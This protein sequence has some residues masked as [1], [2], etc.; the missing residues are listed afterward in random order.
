MFDDFKVNPG[1][2]ILICGKSGSGKSTFLNNLKE[3]LKKQNVC[4]SL[5]MQNFDAQIITDKVFHELAFPLENYGIKPDVIR[6][7]VAEISTYFGIT[8]LLEKDT[9]RLSGGEKQ[10]L[11]LASALITA[12]EILLLDEPASQLDPVASW[13]FFST[14][15]KLNRETGISVVIAEH[16]IE[17]VFPLADRIILLDKM[18]V[19]CEG[20][21]KEFAEN[22]I[23]LDRLEQKDFVLF[24]PAATRLFLEN[25]GNFFEE[26]I[27]LS[28]KDGR[29]WM[30]KKFCVTDGSPAAGV[31]ERKRKNGAQAEGRTAGPDRME[32][33]AQIILKAKNISF[34]YDKIYKKQP[35][36]KDLSFSIFEGEIF[37]IVGANGSG[38][39][40]LLKILQ[41]IL[42]PV[43]GK[44]I[45][46]GKKILMLPQNVKNL[47]TKDSAKMELE[48]CG[49]KGEK[50]CF[51]DGPLNVHPYD[52]SGG[53][54][55]KLAMEKIL[56]KKPDI[57]LLDEPTKGMDNV[58]KKEF[59]SFLK[60][61]VSCKGSRDFL[62]SVVLVCHDLEFCCQTAD[63][64]ALLFEGDFASVSSAESFFAENIFYTTPQIKIKGSGLK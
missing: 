38:K 16:R 41:G 25:G 55:E 10:I 24:L 9:S 59:S 17:E 31:L 2:F 19:I 51:F 42:K 44:I 56:L 4:C 23:R 61:F 13:N 60:E 48:E 64:V 12:P 22:I 28:V 26:E 35:V 45:S 47:F 18:Q 50:L 11:N 34:F 43:N 8:H 1:E 30:Q 53:E 36:L 40:T 21:P 58:F 57:I 52:L 14:L 20:S 32:G 29:L 3:R 6:R 37:G 33:N 54:M 39:S 5:V 46:G 62:P 27:P 7:R 63:K 15:K 49:W